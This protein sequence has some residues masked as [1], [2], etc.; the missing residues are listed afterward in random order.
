MF[1]CFCI[2]N[3]KLTQKDKI[4]LKELFLNSK[5]SNRVI[6]KKINQSKET[7]SKKIN[8]FLENGLIRNYSIGIN[9]KKLGFIEYNLFFKLKKLDELSYQ[10]IINYL[11]ENDNTTWIGKSFGKY[12][13]K[14]SIIFKE[15][16]ELNTFISNIFNKFNEFVDSIDSLYVI[17][18]YKASK[19]LF[20]NN[21]LDLN[22]SIIQ[23]KENRNN[24]SISNKIDNL[25]KSLIY[26]ISQ[27]SKISL[28]ELAIKYSQTAQ[29][30]KYRISNIEKN[31]YITNHSIVFDGNKLN[32]IWCLV[33]LR[34]NEQDL[35]KFKDYLKSDLN[36][37]SYVQTIG[38]WNLNVTFFAKDIESLYYNLNNFRTNFSNEIR[39]FEYMFFFDFYKFPKAPKCIL[40]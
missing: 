13:L 4:L 40:N 8:Q 31:N 21:L 10:K 37:S 22:E 29:G 11:V 14:V 7:I 18:K 25:D 15:Q 26:D 33:L 12:D 17:N 9:Y 28:I 24:I 30:I 1:F 27:T 23:Q 20:L 38:L 32:K 6:S 16:E 5:Q 39:N 36:L 35:N 2:F 34:I 19:Q 3:M